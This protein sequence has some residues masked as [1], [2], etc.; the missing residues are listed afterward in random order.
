[1]SDVLEIK[2]NEGHRCKIV[3]GDVGENI[4][5]LL[6]D[7]GRRV[8]IVTD[9][10]VHLHNRAFIDSF[11]HILVGQGESSKTFKTVEEV[12]RKLLE[13]NADRSTFLLGVGGGIV[14]DITGFV[15]A[16]FMRGIDFGFIA[17]TLLSQVDASVGG[18]NGVNLDGYKNIMGVIVQPEFVICDPAM[19]RTLPEREFRSGLAEIIKAG[20]I[21]DPELFAMFERYSFEEIRKNT[22]IIKDMIKRAVKVKADIVRC[23]ER[24]MGERRKL[25]LGHTFA[26]AMEK[27]LPTFSHGEAVAAGLIQ[28]CGAA[29]KMGKLSPH[30]SERIENVVDK[31]GLPTSYP[32]ETRR[33]LTAVKYDK[34]KD[35]DIIRLVIPLSIGEC[36]IVSVSLDEVES[37]FIA[38]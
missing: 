8:I 32:I 37:L 34:K 4:E 10:N 38:G 1:M 25:N 14:T 36:D 5:E 7:S 22:D 2:C 11:D 27:S 26:H 28:I 13:L 29:V 17:T 21:A 24:E 33:L 12:C 35:K 3:F 20:I 23:D 30:D 18:K 9:A 19:L 31:M 16:T 15:A 6:G